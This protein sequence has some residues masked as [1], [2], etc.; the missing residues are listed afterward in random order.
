MASANAELVQSISAAWMRGDFGSAEWAHP[1]IEYV[2][3]DGPTPGSWTGVPAMARAWRDWLSA[4]EELRGEFDEIREL[5]NERVLELHRFKARGKTS[6][7]ELGQMRTQ[8]AMLFHIRD[9][10]VIRLV[11]WW[12]S[13]NAFADL[14]LP[15]KQGSSRS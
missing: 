13:E 5:D 1:E 11:L 9:G 15:A 7:V 10:K 12:D 2:F 3:A 8:G 4:W 14:G 6:G